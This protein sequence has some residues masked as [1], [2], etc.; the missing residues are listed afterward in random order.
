MI[1]I[2]LEKIK[3]VLPYLSLFKIKN[4]LLFLYEFK[5]QKINLKSLPYEYF[6][7]I[8][9]ICNLKCPLCPTGTNSK[10]RNKKIMSFDVYKKIFNKIKKYAF[11]VKLYNWGEPFLNK[12]LFKIIDY[13]KKK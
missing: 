2:S 12:D 7:D 8:G 13:T 3:D 11:L 1:R 6:I 9:N 4:F 10:K 5:F